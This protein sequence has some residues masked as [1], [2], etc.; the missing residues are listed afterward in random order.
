MKLRILESK[1]TPLI[2]CLNKRRD[3]ETAGLILAERLHGGEVLMVREAVPFPDE[4][5]LIRRNDQLS[6][7]PVVLNRMIRPARDN[8]WSVITVH[9]HPGTNRP[10]FSV[11]DDAGDSRL[12][13]SLF[14]QMPGPHGSMVIAGDTGMA[15]GRVWSEMGEKFDLE[16]RIVGSTLRIA[17]VVLSADCDASWFDRQRLALGEAGQAAIRDLHVTIAGLGG[18]GSV[19]FVQLAHLGVRRITVI[20]GDRVDQSNISRILGASVR[21]ADGSWKVDVAAR[22]AETLGLGTEV[23]CFRGHL[24]RD[25]SPVEIEGSD[26]MLSCVDRHLPR[27][28][29]NRLSYEKAVPLIDM[30]SGFRVDS[31]GRMLSGAGRVVITGPGRPCLACWGHID[32]DRIR[33]ESLPESD[34]ERAVADGYIDRAQIRQPSVIAFNTM[35]AGAAVV[36]VMGL[37]TEFAGCDDLPMRLN[38]DFETGTVRRNRLAEWKCCR[39]CRPDST[40]TREGGADFQN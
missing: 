35:V 5:Y 3:V 40:P 11:A 37:V 24:G 6:L 20:D 28:L 32:P 23:R 30:G 38:F 19:S 8:G 12:M 25:V 36:E 29:M 2:E 22:Y 21:D 14:T 34:R 17:P 39:I 16:T 26:L 33:I 10:W 31:D 27:A 1:W 9:T 7:D 4:G 15:A 13:P 18:T